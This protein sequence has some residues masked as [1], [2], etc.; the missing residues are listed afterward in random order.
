MIRAAD[1]LGASWPSRLLGSL[2]KAGRGLNLTDEVRD[3]I[4]R[5]SKGKGP[6]LTTDPERLTKTLEAQVV[7]LADIVAYLNH[8]LDDA[9]RAEAAGLVD[10][11]KGEGP[12]SEFSGTRKRLY[13]L[14][15]LVSDFK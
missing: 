1:A 13:T 6:I 12:F 4:V 3:G 8:D 10:A 5:H 9:L 15:R 11:L 2:E 7:R 14:S